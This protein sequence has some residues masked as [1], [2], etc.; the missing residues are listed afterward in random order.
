MGN[1]LCKMDKKKKKKITEK[2]PKYTCK[3]CGN[4]AH[5]EKFLCKPVG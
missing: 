1:K 4:T 3:S 5:K 2:E